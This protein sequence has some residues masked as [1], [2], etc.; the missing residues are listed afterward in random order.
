MRHWVRAYLSKKIVPSKRSASTGGYL[1]PQE[2]IWESLI[3]SME[4]N[5]KGSIEDNWAVAMSRAERGVQNMVKV[6]ED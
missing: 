4:S 3:E 5:D 2:P 6:L 1:V